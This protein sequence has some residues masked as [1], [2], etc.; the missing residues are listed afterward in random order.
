V[1]ILCS[2]EVMRVES[3]ADGNLIHCSDGNEIKADCIIL[4]AGIRLNLD[5]AKGADLEIEN[6][7]K[8]KANMQ[9]SVE[10]VFAIGDIAFHF[11]PIYQSYVRIESVPNAVA[12]ARVAASAI[13]GKEAAHEE[14][15]WFWSDQYDLKFQTAGLLNGYE[16]SILRK[17]GENNFSLWYFKREQLLAVDAINS[18]RAYMM[19]RKLI[20]QKSI[21]DKD[22]LRDVESPLVAKELVAEF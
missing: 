5:L 17:E 22:K 9:T 13:C 8:V 18:P 19:G 12:Q 7:I 21:I 14:V 20:G 16:E 2:K 6:G 3:L 11:N 1:E 4:G 10:D 15:P